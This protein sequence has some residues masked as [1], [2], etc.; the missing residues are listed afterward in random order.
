MDTVLPR[1]LTQ[2]LKDF[3]D[4]IVF[5]FHC[6]KI[7]RIIDFDKHKKTASIQILFK[8]TLP[9]GDIQSENKLVNCP[10]FTLQGGG[11]YIQMPISKGDDCIVIFAD[12][13]IEAWRKSGMEQKPIGNWAHS[14]KDGIAIVGLNSYVS[15]MPDNEEGTLKIGKGDFVL[16]IKDGKISIKNNITDLYTLIDGLLSI[17]A[18]LKTPNNLIDPTQAAQI[19]E[20]QT[21]LAQLLY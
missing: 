5:G 12:R 18:V 9:N 21:K 20:I 15:N 4:D 2:A 19:K 7:G 10:V 14:L 3:K 1:T 8:K 13:S 6:I 16:R 11:A 17:L